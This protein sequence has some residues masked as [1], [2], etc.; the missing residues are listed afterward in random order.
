MGPKTHEHM[1]LFMS[2]M[3]WGLMIHDWGAGTFCPN[4]VRSVLAS[5]VPALL[6]Y[7]DSVR[8]VLT[9]SVPEPVGVAAV[10]LMSVPQVQQHAAGVHQVC[11]ALSVWSVV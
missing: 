9:S 3:S 8:S 10:C 4:R 11:F 1:T 6:G 7:L 2:Y 5:S